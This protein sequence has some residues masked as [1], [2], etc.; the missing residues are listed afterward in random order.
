M[1]DTLIP[2]A[3]TAGQLHKLALEYWRA[4]QQ[5]DALS[6]MRRAL[7]MEEENV[8][9]RATL[10][11]FLTNAGCLVESTYVLAHAFPNLF[12]FGFP[13]MLLYLS[14]DVSNEV[15]V[16]L[17]LLPRVLSLKW[18]LTNVPRESLHNTA[19]AISHGIGVG[20]FLI[21]NSVRLRFLRTLL[22]RGETARLL[23][24]LDALQTHSDK[25][26]PAI[27]RSLE[28]VAL[29]ISGQ[30]E[31]ARAVLEDLR[32]NPR[33]F[34]LFPPAETLSIGPQSGLVSQ[35]F[36][37]SENFRLLAE[38]MCGEIPIDHCAAEDSPWHILSTF[39][40]STHDSLALHLMAVTAYNAG[41]PASFAADFWNH[42]A[43]LHPD[44]QVAEELYHCAIHDALPPRPMPYPWRLSERSAGQNRALV[45]TLCARETKELND[46]WEQNSAFRRAL[47]WLMRTESDAFAEVAPA[48]CEKLS[49]E[50]LRDLVNDF[51]YATAQNGAHLLHL[52][53][54]LPE[55]TQRA[56]CHSLF[57]GFS[58]VPLKRMLAIRAARI[59][60]EQ[61]LGSAISD[62]LLFWLDAGIRRHHGRN[63]HGH[64]MQIVWRCASLMGE[65]GNARRMARLLNI[66]PRLAEYRIRAA[67]KEIIP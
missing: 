7:S 2:F 31:R 29:C 13:M 21:R 41:A 43:R 33:G 65:D 62:S 15:G 46:A 20:R 50:H 56:F 49:S 8:E 26:R 11:R 51:C 5:L 19:L 52:L 27:Y 45:S 36:T 28:C 39:N 25:K 37:R 47:R 30:Q 66:S 54:A 40:R 61:L 57:A 3:P 34:F 4:G 42:I 32:R 38:A 59:G 55:E 17:A 24:F 6:L 16:P 58:P 23:R 22:L 63:I 64:A 14:I 1:S 67:K 35:L 18:F 60:L 10:A 53:A 9:Y 12:H 44:D 48:L